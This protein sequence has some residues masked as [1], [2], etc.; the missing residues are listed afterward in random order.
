MTIIADERNRSE[1]RRASLPLRDVRR[2]RPAVPAGTLGAAAPA[3]RPGC[4]LGR[5]SKDGGCAGS[6]AVSAQRERLQLRG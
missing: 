6:E 3:A 1:A 2:H 4:M 5:C